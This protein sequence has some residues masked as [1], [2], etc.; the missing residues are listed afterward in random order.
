M[1]ALESTSKAL[2]TA[3]ISV[4]RLIPLIPRGSLL[5]YC[6]RR[7]PRKTI[8]ER[9]GESWTTPGDFLIYPIN[10]LTGEDE[11]PLLLGLHFSLTLSTY[12]SIYLSLYPSNPPPPLSL[13]VATNNIYILLRHGIYIRY[14]KYLVFTFQR[15]G[16]ANYSN[17]CC[18][19]RISRAFLS[20]ENKTKKCRPVNR[21]TDSLLRWSRRVSVLVRR[22]LLFVGDGRG[23]VEMVVGR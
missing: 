21:L 2:S 14:T 7:Q 11:S 16:E 5:F 4:G 12:L 1:A 13:S 23:R 15:T 18:S 10:L 6:I 17:R 9:R 3:D 19:I 8:S 20:K 22:I